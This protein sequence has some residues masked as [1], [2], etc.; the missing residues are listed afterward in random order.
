MYKKEVIK[1]DRTHEA[2]VE[3]RSIRREQDSVEQQVSWFIDNRT[4]DELLSDPEYIELEA[5]A[6]DLFYKERE[7]CKEIERDEFMSHEARLAS[8]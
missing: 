2:I 5:Q 4:Q 6:F 3:L 8:V 7:L 1:I